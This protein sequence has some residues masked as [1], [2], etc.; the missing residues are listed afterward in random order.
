MNEPVE[1]KTAAKRLGIF[2]LQIAAGLI[3]GGVAGFLIGRQLA[4][5]VLPAFAEP[6]VHIINPTA[7]IVGSLVIAF[8]TLTGA[9]FGALIAYF[10]SVV[11]TKFSG[12]GKKAKTW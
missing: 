8:S 2:I 11:W 3:F 10:I 1:T 5:V 6:S 4:P 9:I 7:I 12:G